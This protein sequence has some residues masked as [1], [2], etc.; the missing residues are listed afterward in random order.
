MTLHPPSS[1]D[2]KQDVNKTYRMSGSLWVTLPLK[3]KHSKKQQ[4]CSLFNNQSSIINVQLR[5]LFR[6]KYS[7]NVRKS[8]RRFD[9]SFGLSRQTLFFGLRWVLLYSWGLLIIFL[10]TVLLALCKVLWNNF[11]VGRV[12]GDTHCLWTITCCICIL[13]LLHNERFWIVGGA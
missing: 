6:E 5:S 1:W 10:Y 4:Q 11:E 13:F 8:N 2:E 3:D 7:C 12:S 9:L